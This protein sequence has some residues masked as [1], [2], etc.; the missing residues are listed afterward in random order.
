MVA[1]DGLDRPVL[2]AVDPVPSRKPPTRPNRY[3]RLVLR[4]LASVG[5]SEWDVGDG[6][7]DW[8]Y[9]KDLTAVLIDDGVLLNHA[10]SKLRDLVAFGWAEKKAIQGRGW[11]VYRLTEAGREV[12]AQYCGDKDAAPQ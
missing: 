8:V 5:G 4:R 6:E 10:Y 9:G 12:V 1:K 2:R 7:W 3:Q 11:T